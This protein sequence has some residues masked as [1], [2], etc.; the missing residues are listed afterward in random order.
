MVS[1]IDQEISVHEALNASFRSDS[2]DDL[3]RGRG[4][5][6]GGDEDAGR[7][8]VCRAVLG[9]GAHLLDADVSVVEELNPNGADVRGAVVLEVLLHHLLA[10]T[11]GELHS[12]AAVD[13]YQYG[14]V[15][16]PS[17]PFS[18]HCLLAVKDLT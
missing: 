10:G 7:E 13:V 1:N 16:V 6:D 2:G 18:S 15:A 9:E 12:F 17:C 4:D 11:R 14:S 8:V 5:S 3:E